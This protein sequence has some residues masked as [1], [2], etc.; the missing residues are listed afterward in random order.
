M[1]VLVT[2]AGG[3]IGGHLVGSLI[4][5]GYEVYATDI[6]PI[7][8]WWQ[9]HDCITYPGVDLVD[10]ENAIGIMEPR[11]QWVFDLAEDMGGI[12]YITSH[13]IGCGDSVRIG[14]NLL[15][16]ASYWEVERFLF[17][18]SACVYNTELQLHY[19]SPPELK[20]QDAWP[21][22]P[23]DGY[24]LSKLYI[25]EMCRYYS[26]ETKLEVRI[27]RLHNVYGT[28]GSWT[29]GR[30][31]APA[32]LCRK[33]AEAK[34]HN[35]HE[36]EVWG[37]GAQTRSYLHVSDCV[38][39]L[40]ALMRSSFETPINLGSDTVISIDHL[41]QLIA[42]VADWPIKI[43]HGPGP[44]GVAGRNADITLARKWLRW[45]PTVSLAKGL[46]DLYSW[47]E[48]QLKTDTSSGRSAPRATTNA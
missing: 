38:R 6:K 20:E 9:Q 18:S 26:E 47:I 1:R 42:L 44:I 30:E 8:Q 33:I 46:F 4:N 43:N 35:L 13:R 24:G 45:S 2:G 41:A 22:Q 32:A 21:A 36:I 12:G 27:A 28:H 3:A 48:D 14:L 5:D 11:P 31:K 16:A 25:E 17:T 37:S 10:R 40:R 29:G 39:G 34:L 19:N 7:R 23:E 15:H